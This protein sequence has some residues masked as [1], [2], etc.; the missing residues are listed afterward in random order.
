MTEVND[1]DDILTKGM[2][3][4]ER[5]IRFHRGNHPWLPP[6]ARALLDIQFWKITFSSI[7]N[8]KTRQRAID[9]IIN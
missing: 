5:S 3:L 6:L 7:R 2:L 4:A 8:K 9:S 1:I